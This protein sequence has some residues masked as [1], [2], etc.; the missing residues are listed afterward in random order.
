MS[1]DGEERVGGLAAWTPRVVPGMGR[2]LSAEQELACALRHLDDVGFSENMS[3]HITWQQPGRDTILVN[4]W[5]YWWSEV[6]A[7]HI[8]EIDNDGAVVRGELDVTPAIPIHTELHRRRPDARVVVHTH[9][10]YTSVFAAIGELPPIVHQN[11]SLLADEMVLVRDYDG[12]VDSPV[13]GA[14]LA[15]AIGDASVAVLVS[16]GVIVTA[17]T[18]AEAIYKSIMFERACELAWR[19]RATGEV[20]VPIAPVLQKQLKASLVERAAEVYWNG[21]VRQLLQREPEVL[22]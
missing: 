5:G 4:P 18:M 19:V 20:A 17:P 13:L 3:G 11:G 7:R 6:R 12:E 16:H 2:E 21:A 14:A 22:D 15:E 10:I 1:N 8:V 9:P